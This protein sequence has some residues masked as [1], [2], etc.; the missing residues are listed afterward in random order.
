[1]GGRGLAFFP[2]VTR[3]KTRTAR[4]KIRKRGDFGNLR[5]KNFMNWIFSVWFFFL[6][7]DQSVFF[8]AVHVRFYSINR[9]RSWSFTMSTNMRS[10]YSLSTTTVLFLRF[11]ASNEI[12]SNN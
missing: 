5:T 11:G 10:T 6:V 4:M 12:S 3:A 1:M 9:L 2:Q 8:Q 7:T